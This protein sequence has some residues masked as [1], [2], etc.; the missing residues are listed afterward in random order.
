M[1]VEGK[2]TQAENSWYKDQ[3]QGR[4]L[5]SLFQNSPEARRVGAEW[6]KGMGEKGE[7]ERRW[8]K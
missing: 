1:D 3:I 2:K 6:M 8:Q 7:A 4:S 5:L